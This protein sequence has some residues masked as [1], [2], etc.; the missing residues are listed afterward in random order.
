MRFG[1]RDRIGLIEAFMSSAESCFSCL[2][3]KLGYLQPDSFDLD[4][5]DESRTSDS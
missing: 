5:N 3:V 2:F 1:V 4:E